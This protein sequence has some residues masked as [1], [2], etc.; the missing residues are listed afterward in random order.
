M[1]ICNRRSL[2]AAPVTRHRPAERKLKWYRTVDSILA[3]MTKVFPG[4]RLPFHVQITIV[5]FARQVEE[6]GRSV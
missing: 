4:E 3:D 6:T 2:E 1:K 5:D